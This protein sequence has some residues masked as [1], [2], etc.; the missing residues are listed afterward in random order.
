MDI[1]N[2]KLKE[3]TMRDKLSVNQQSINLAKLEQ[4][5]RN[6]GIDNTNRNIDIILEAA[7]CPDFEEALKM[8]NAVKPSPKAYTSYLTYNCKDFIKIGRFDF[9]YKM[10]FQLFD[11]NKFMYRLNDYATDKAFEQLDEQDAILLAREAL[12]EYH[13]LNTYSYDFF[14]QLSPESVLELCQN[15]NFL[16]QPNDIALAALYLHYGE[17][18]N[19]QDLAV[20]E[21][22]INPLFKKLGNIFGG[23]SANSQNFDLTKQL[24][25]HIYYISPLLGD[26][27][28][29][30]DCFNS[31]PSKELLKEAQV[32]KSNFVNYTYLACSAFNKSEFLQKFS[33]TIFICQDILSKRNT[34][35]CSEKNFVALGVN[36]EDFIAFVNKFNANKT[37]IIAQLHPNMSAKFKDTDGLDKNY[38]IE[39][40]LSFIK[41][42][43]LSNFLHEKEDMKNLTFH[44]ETKGRIEPKLDIYENLFE[45]DELY[46]RMKFLQALCS[47]YDFSAE[48]I[49]QMK[50]YNLNDE[51][52]YNIFDTLCNG[53]IVNEFNRAELENRTYKKTEAILNTYRGKNSVID[54][55]SAN[56]KN[57]SIETRFVIT[58]LLGDNIETY[59]D[60]FLKITDTSK[61]IQTAIAKTYKQHPEMAEPELER[62]KNKKAP[63]RKAAFNILKNA[64]GSKYNE[65]INIAMQ[66]ET[67]AKLKLEMEDHLNIIE[68]IDDTSNINFSKVVETLNKNRRKVE[69]LFS[70]EMPIV[71]DVDGNVASDE[72]LTACLVAYANEPIAGVS[73]LGAILA[74]KLNVTEFE[75]YAQQAFYNFMEDGAE[76][77]KKWVIYFSS[78]HGGFE[79]VNIL[80]SNIAKWAENSRGAIAGE[81]T[82]ALAL[83]P[84]P[85]AL[86]TVDGMSRKY[87]FKQVKNAAIDAM[88]F[89]AQQLKI[90]TD[91]LSDRIV[92]D[93]GFD[94]SL[95]LNFDYGNRN[96]D[97]Y[98]NTALELEVFDQKGKKIKTLPAVGKTDE[99]EIA[100]AAL[101][102]F[103]E[104]K[105]QL[106]ATAT[107]Q[108]DRLEMALS[109]GRKWTKEAYEKLFVKNP[110]MHQFAIGL[111]WGIYENNTVTE[112][113]R[114]ME[115]GSFNSAE[116]DEIELGDNAIIGIVHPLELD[117]TLLNTWREQLSDY[118]VIQPLLQLERTIYT[119]PNEIKD[120]K[121]STEMAGKILSPATLSNKMLSQ[122]WQRGEIMDAGFYENYT[123]ENQALGLCAQLHFSGNCVGYYEEGPVT[124]KQLMFYKSEHHSLGDWGRKD[125]HFIKLSEVDP[126]FYSEILNQIAKATST[127]TETEINWR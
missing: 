119:V 71:H 54:K 13:T 24:E 92:P 15:F 77:K 63:E 82:K 126:K 10:F 78:I 118:E 85:I 124:L 102:Q 97:V 94:E 107:T 45:K 112:T 88:V 86:L 23:S 25:Q 73:Y 127:S 8:L 49:N 19:V 80:K 81:A 62:L 61:T 65:Q 123:K 64:Y 106:K 58:L 110:I 35:I 91:E 109:D 28:N 36:V 104:L 2:N 59:K 114:Y 103:K 66:A 117:E 50:E 41:A 20:Q 120:T 39:H 52:L 34:S 101:K 51:N 5:L 70:T 79:M 14:K 111:V 89:A 90:T 98:L 1:K 83:N 72:F 75:A 4:D 87:K 47:Y 96:F 11:I 43:G 93:L 29:N 46:K 30:F 27:I 67:N 26:L 100:T 37:A 122:G 105:K 48:T 16:K 9:F 113:F 7:A 116:E 21:T 6:S 42:G 60:A 12:Y 53:D 115:D 69:F 44:I 31:V 99:T 40:T 55:L 22:K 17:M 3:V 76:A 95:K 32:L 18:Q 57:F 33:A 108:R 84:A 38:F 56:Y 74:Q 68:D 125:N 121:E